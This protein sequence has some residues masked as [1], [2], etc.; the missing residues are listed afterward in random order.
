MTIENRE[1]DQP[2]NDKKFT[3]TSILF[4]LWSYNNE[5]SI[6]IPLINKYKWRIK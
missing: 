6:L 3:G 2:L 5:G 1:N 4:T